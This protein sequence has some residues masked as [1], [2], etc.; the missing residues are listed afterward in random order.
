VDEQP[1]PIN[2]R[3]VSLKLPAP[4]STTSVSSPVPHNHFRL[5]GGTQNVF[6]NQFRPT[7]EKDDE[8]SVILMPPSRQKDLAIAAKA[9]IAPRAVPPI[10]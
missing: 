10:L 6:Q 9:C 5:C 7:G 1:T 3:H 8:K 4:A 2:H